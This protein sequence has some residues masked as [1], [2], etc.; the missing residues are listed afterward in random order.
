[1]STRLVSLNASSQSALRALSAKAGPTRAAIAPQSNPPRTYQT[2]NGRITDLHPARSSDQQ[3]EGLADKINQVAHSILQ[4]SHNKTLKLQPKE[5]KAMMEYVLTYMHTSNPPRYVHPKRNGDQNN[6]V[7]YSFTPLIDRNTRRMY[8][9][10]IHGS[11]VGQGSFSIAKDAAIVYLNGS[12]NSGDWTVET[13][14]LKKTK[15]E[16]VTRNP[17]LYSKTEQRKASLKYDHPNQKNV[18]QLAKH[19]GTLSPKREFMIIPRALGDLAHYKLSSND[20]VW[21]CIV[22]MCLG[23]QFFHDQGRLVRDFKPEN[24]LVYIDENGKLLHQISDLDMIIEEDPV[25]NKG[26]GTPLFTPKDL[27]LG[28]SKLSKKSDIY[29]L[30]VSIY[31]IITNRIIK[32]AD[33]STTMTVPQYTQLL[34]SLNPFR[35]IKEVPDLHMIMQNLEELERSLRN[36]SINHPIRML[37][38]NLIESNELIN[39]LGLAKKLMH[40]IAEERPDIEKVLSIAQNPKAHITF[41]QNEPKPSMLEEDTSPEQDIDSSTLHEEGRVSRMPNLQQPKA[42]AAD[43]FK[44]ID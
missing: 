34:A 16:R 39:L 30:G 41:R 38:M 18:E 9:F 43:S 7:R 36:P 24:V 11:Q 44:K 19:I 25:I 5:A 14:V 40:P 1:M 26:P 2:L 3:S 15:K 13:N 32:I 8:A 29:A 12:E 20:S 28:F 27:L 31:K 35:N 10:A 22:Q 17:N 4:P 37:K 42:A 33:E 21:N 23:M 6:Q